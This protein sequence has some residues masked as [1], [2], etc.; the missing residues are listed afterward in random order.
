MNFAAPAFLFMA[1]LAVPVL[2]LAWRSRAPLSRLQLRILGL[3]QAAAILCGAVALARPWSTSVVGQVHRVVVWGGAAPATA[4]GTVAA[5]RAEVPH[6]DP[7]TVVRAGAV[8]V[9]GLPG[10]TSVPEANGTPDLVAALRAAVALVPAGAQAQIVLCTDGQHDGASLAAATNELAARGIPVVLHE[11][12]PPAVA[13]LRLL[14]VAHAPRVGAGEAFRIDVTIAAVAAGTGRL[15][16]RDGA[17]T[18]GAAEVTM[19]P[20]EQQRHVDVVLQR[21]GPVELSVRLLGTG[22][23]ED[24]AVAGPREERTAVLVDAG[25]RVLHLTS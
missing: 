16:V 19:Q 10:A 1:L 21:T 6:R 5:L 15:E 25:L 23:G 3:L 24:A 17:T 20:G 11:L 14:R 12:A 9:V 8:P 13:P 7:F 4:A 2:V 22:V 18:V